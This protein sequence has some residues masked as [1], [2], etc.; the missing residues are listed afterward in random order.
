MNVQ[1]NLKY[2]DKSHTGCHRESH[3]ERGVW[4]SHSRQLVAPGRAVKQPLGAIGIATSGPGALPRKD[5]AF[6]MSKHLGHRAGDKE[7]HNGD[8]SYDEGIGELGIDVV[9]VITGRGHG[10]NNGGV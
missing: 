7:C 10:G 1:Y 3:A 8:P 2:D 5:T 4:R 9:Y 6:R